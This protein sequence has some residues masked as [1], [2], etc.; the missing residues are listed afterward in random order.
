M[1]ETNS[2][3]EPIVTITENKLT[4]LSI[5]SIHTLDR[6]KKQCGRLEVNNRWVR[7]IRNVLDV[8]R[9]TLNSLIEMNQLSSVYLEIV[10]V[11]HYQKKIFR[12]LKLKRKIS[13][14]NFINLKMTFWMNLMNL[15]LN[16]FK[17]LNHL[18]IVFLILDQ[19][20]QEAKNI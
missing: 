13:Q 7:W 20:T 6:N 19:K 4:L 8:F 9:K 11:Y 18:K 16:F 1:G 17:K 2:D 10:N 14:N 15:K 5:S 12:K 3:S